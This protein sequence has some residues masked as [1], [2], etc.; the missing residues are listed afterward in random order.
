MSDRIGSGRGGRA[1]RSRPEEQP[2]PDEQTGA[3]KPDRLN[4]HSQLEIKPVPDEREFARHFLE[5]GSEFLDLLERLVLEETPSDDPSAFGGIFRFLRERFEQ[6][7][8]DVHHVKGRSSAGQLVCLPRGFDPDLPVQLIL[9]HCDTV[10]PIGTLREMPFTREGNVVAGPGIYDM[11]A[12]IAMMVCAMDFLRKRGISP[13]LQPVFLITTDEETG[14]LDSKELIIEWARRAER[15]FVLEP[16][17]GLDGKIKTE[18]K[19]VGQ[20]QIT[21]TGKPSHAGLAPEEGVSAILG[22]SQIVQMLFNL[23][24][25]HRGISV[26]V[27]TIEGGERSNVIAA[28]SRASVDVRVRSAED[29]ERITRA[30]RELKPELEGVI[31][32]VSGGIYRPPMEKGEA[33]EILWQQT[34]WIGSRL[35]IELEEVLAGGGS[36]GNFTNLFSPTI[37][38]MGAVG[39]GAHAWHE[40]IFLKETLQRAA[41][42]ARLLLEPSLFPEQEE[43]IQ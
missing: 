10:W 3:G 36:D 13:T 12:G 38:G 32:E 4:Q 17:L 30:I 5:C 1:E 24:D 11:K 19:G 43:R 23:N 25:P 29:G 27:G 39:D 40:R 18:R 28:R 9:G 15:T 42:F 20:F 41:L 2:G 8:M 31:Y 34:R 35:G 22:L 26:N 33:N 37:D 16:S 7:G 6:T 14:S 21:V